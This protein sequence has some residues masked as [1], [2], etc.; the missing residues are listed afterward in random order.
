MCGQGRGRVPPLSYG[1]MCRFDGLH[2]LR[3]ENLPHLVR[4]HRLA[5]QE[6]LHLTA[7]F[8]PDHVELLLGF[9]TLSSRARSS[10]ARPSSACS[11]AT[12]LPSAWTARARG[13]TTCSSSGCGAASSTRRCICGPT[14]ASVRHAA[15]SAAISTSTMADAHIR[16]LTARHPI[17][18]T[19]PRCPS[20]WQP[21]PGGSST[22]RSGNS[23]Q[24]TGTTSVLHGAL[25]QLLRWPRNG[26]MP[27]AW[28]SKETLI[29]WVASPGT[30]GG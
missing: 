18:P 13:G 3:G 12:P 14:T 11:P 30:P 4:R 8:R 27:S 15:R 28:R 7:A 22:Y 20:A 6:S 9:H 1:E 26:A 2:L 23:V 16:A 24:T 19:S 29:L 17:K 21:N 25:V 10:R 5:Q